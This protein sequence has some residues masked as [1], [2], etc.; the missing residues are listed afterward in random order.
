MIRT[1]IATLC[2]VAALY[3]GL[4]GALFLAAPNHAFERFGV[5]PPND[6]GYVQ[7]PAALLIVFALMFVAIAFDPVRHRN[8]LPFTALLKVSYVAV[9]GLHWLGAGIPSMWKPF[10]VFDVIFLALLVWAYVAAGKLTKP[11][12]ATAQ[13][14]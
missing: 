3:D 8:L 5:T 4:L 2:V 1:A 13:P 12:G 10:V 9:A 6:I 7:F 14:A 11:G